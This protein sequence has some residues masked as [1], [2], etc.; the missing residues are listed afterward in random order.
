M[1]ATS[2]IKAFASLAFVLALILLFSHVLR[3]YGSEKMMA[4]IR[5]D[6]GEKRLGVVEAAMIDGRRKL[7]LIR[8]DGV[9]HLIL[10]SPD[11]ETVIETGIHPTVEAKT[12]KVE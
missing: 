6:G 3:K 9:E 7:V 10:L 1:E 11:K 8:R 4:R 2:I 5:K 12:W